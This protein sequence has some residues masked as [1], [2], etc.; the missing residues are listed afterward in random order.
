[1]G[2][3][4]NSDSVILGRLEGLRWITVD[5]PC[6]INKNAIVRGSFKCATKIGQAVLHPLS[7]VS[8]QTVGDGVV[9]AIRSRTNTK[10][11]IKTKS[12][13]YFGDPA[14]ECE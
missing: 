2:A 1:M 9:L 10:R 12:G 5:K 8:E 6:I 14:I 7:F 11:I 13:M 4:I 3:K